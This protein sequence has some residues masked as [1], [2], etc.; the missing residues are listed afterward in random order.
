[1]FNSYS[2]SYLNPIFG[3]L[4]EFF[5]FCFHWLLAAKVLR[6][7]IQVC[8]RVND[9]IITL[10]FFALVFV[11]IFCFT[12]RV[13]VCVFFMDTQDIVICRKVVKYSY[14]SIEEILAVFLMFF[15]FFFYLMRLSIHCGDSVYSYSHNANNC[16]N[17]RSH[18]YK[19]LL[20]L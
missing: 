3:F 4:S 6:V 1:M 8:V 2:Y 10:F 17:L 19:Y 9:F 14:H 7:E 16:D 18:S 12:A 15:F 5:F 20:F 13:C 11:W